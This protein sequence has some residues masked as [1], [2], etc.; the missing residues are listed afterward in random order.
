M[1]DHTDGTGFGKFVPGFEF[2]QNLARQATSGMTQGVQQAMPQ[3]PSLGNWV[4]PTFNVEELEKRIQELKAVQFWLDQNS[5][6][7]AAT[8]QAL[9]VQ[10]M[11]LATLKGM[12]FNLGDVAQV[13]RST[14]FGMAMPDLASGTS[15]TPMQT[16]AQ[17][18]QAD[19][20]ASGR[21]RFEG[22]EVPPRAPQSAPQPAAAAEPPAQPPAAAKPPTDSG[23]AADA[24][25]GLDPM[26]WWGSIT[27]QFQTIASQAM[28]DVTDQASHMASVVGSVNPVE[29]AMDAAKAVVADVVKAAGNKGQNAAAKSDKKPMARGTGK[30]AASKAVTQPAAKSPPR[31]AAD[32]KTKMATKPA[33]KVVAKAPVKPA[34]KASSAGAKAKTAQRKVAR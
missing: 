4:A 15:A 20:Q 33:A 26:Q 5:R 13:L 31:K 22:L 16:A 11:T 27:Q 32:A 3:M 19:H 24:A 30:T 17:T 29:S 9:E 18:S 21:T 25:P 10:K 2:L 23:S 1:A 7:L 12:N 8:I 34:V 28:K 6:A 14:P